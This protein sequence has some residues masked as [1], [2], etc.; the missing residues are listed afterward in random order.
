[1]A[2]LLLDLE[3]AYDKV[4]WPFVLTTIRRMGFR[5][6]D[7]ALGS[8][9]YLN[10]TVFLAD[11]SVGSF[12]RA[13]VRK[14]IVRLS[15]LWSSLLGGWKPLSEVRVVLIG[16]QEVES[17]WRALINALPRE[18]TTILGPQGTD[19]AGT[20][21]IPQQAREEDLVLWKLLEIL[22]SGFKR[23]ERW[24]CTGPENT[25][26]LLE[27][28]TV[29]LWENPA[30][31]R[32]LEV[33]SKNR[34]VRIL[35][36]VRRLPLN[37]LSIDPTAWSWS[38]KDPGKEPLDL[39]NYTVAAGYKQYRHKLKSPAQRAIPLWQAVC[40]EDLSDAE[41][42]FEGLWSIMSSLPN[43]K[44]AHAEVDSPPLLCSYED[45]AARLIPTLGTHAQGQDM[46]AASSP[47]GSGDL[48]SSSGS[49]RNSA[50]EFNIEV[51]DPLTSEDFAWLPLLTTGRLPGPQCAALCAHLHTYLSFYAPPTSLTDDEAA[52]GDIIVYV[53][54]LAR[55][56]RKQRYND[57]NAPLLY[58]RIQVGQASCSALLD[59]GASRNFMSQAFM[60]RAGLGTQVR[61]KAN[62]T[63]INLADGRTQQLIDRYIEAVP[64]YFAP[65]ACEPVMFDILNTDF[66]IVL[67]MP[68]L[69]SADHK[70]NFHRRTLTVR[71]AFGAEVSCTIPLPHPPIRCQVVTAKSFRATCAYEQPGEIGLCF[72]LTVAVAD[73]SPT[74]LSSDPRVVRLLDEF[75]DIFESPTGVVPDRPISHEIILEAGAVPLK[76][77]IYR[78]SEEELTVLCAQLDNLLD[79]GWIRPSNSPYGAPVLF[80]RKKNRNLRLCI[81]YRKLNAQTVKNAGPLPRI[82][83][84]LE[85]LGGATYF[86][87][88]DL[89][90]GYHQILIRSNNRYK[91]AFKTRY[92][93]FEWVVMPFRLTN[94]PTTFQAA[95]TNEFRTVL[96]RFVLVYLD[97][98]LL[99]PNGGLPDAALNKLMKMAST[100]VRFTG[101]KMLRQDSSSNLSRMLNKFQQVF[102]RPDIH[103]SIQ[104]TR[105]LAEYT[106][107]HHLTV[108][109]CTCEVNF[110]LVASWQAQNH[111]LGDTSGGH[112]PHHLHL[113]WPMV[114]KASEFE[115][116]I[117][118]DGVFFGWSLGVSGRVLD[119]GGLGGI[120]GEMLGQYGSNGEV[121]GISGDI[122][123]VSGVGDL[124]DRGRGDWLLEEVESVLA[125][126][127][128]IE[129]LV[130]ACESVKRVRDLGKVENE[131]AVIVGKV[132][133]GTELKEGLERGVL[134][135]GCDLRGVHMDA[136]SGD[137]VAKDRE[138]LANV[139]KVGL[140][141]GAK[142]E[143]V[144]KVQDDTDVEEVTTDVVHGGLECGGGI[145]ESERHYEELVVPGP[146]A[147]CGLVGILLA[148]TDLV[149]ATAEVDLGEIF[150]SLEAIKKFRYPG[151][152][153]LVLDR[154]PVQG[155]FVET[156]GW[157]GRRRS[158]G[159]I[160]VFHPHKVG[161]LEVLNGELRGVERGSV[162]VVIEGGWSGVVR[163]YVMEEAGAER[164][165]RGRVMGVEESIVVKH[166]REEVSKRHV[167][168]VGEG[169]CEI[170]VA[171]S[172]DAGDERRVGN[173]GGG[174]VMAEGA[175][176]LDEAVRGT[177]LAEVTKLFE[178]VIDGFLGAEG[179]SEKVGPLEEGVTRSSGGAAVAD[180]GHPPFGGIVEEAGGGNGKPMDKGHVVE[181]ERV[182]E[183]D[184]EEE[185]VLVGKAGEGHDVGGSEGTG[186]LPFAGNDPGEGVEVEVIG[187][188]VVV[189]VIELDVVVKEVVGGKLWH[190]GVN[191]EDMLMEDWVM[192]G[193]EGV[194][195]GSR[196]EVEA[197]AV[198]VIAAAVAPAA[199]AAAALAAAR[200]EVLVWR[201]GM[202]RWGGQFL[203]TRIERHQSSL[204]LK[205]G[206]LYAFEAA[207]G[208]DCSFVMSVLMATAVL[209]IVA[210]PCH[211]SNSATSAV[212]H[213]QCHASSAASATVPR[214]QQCHV[215]NSAT[216]AVPR[217]Q[218]HVSNSVTSACPATMTGAALGM[219]G[220]LANESL[221]D[222][223]QRFQDQLA[224]IEAEEQR[225]PAAEAARL[226]AEAAA[227][228]EK[229][230]LQAE[231]DADA[232]ARRKEAQD[233]LRRHE[234]ASI[235]RLKFRHF[236]PSNGD[237]ATPEE[238][239]KEFLSKLMTRLLYACNYQ[240][241]ELERQNQEL[242]QQYQDLKTQHQELANL[243]RIV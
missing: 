6:G 55:E 153:V 232:Q 204:M 241:S 3:K 28:V 197:V 90:S 45:Y 61:R 234:A 74:D 239:H 44:Q 177:G 51:W 110:F 86:S 165:G 122:E 203:F 162:E 77:C 236:Q 142:D 104:G 227:T 83:D 240:Q 229:Q 137:N 18:W 193:E 112:Y 115:I 10:G 22:P 185:N 8:K 36:W 32:V 219:P 222:Y 175:N 42:D 209:Q 224:L 31:A 139:L 196:A 136:F 129:G 200:W 117:P 154:D 60:Q 145:G 96:D 128:P 151:E 190:C 103:A 101:L 161:G 57:N 49:S 7:S 202:W 191:P 33:C 109:D 208:R 215:S 149:E 84:L 73:S 71:D 180:F 2:V 169:G 46:C 16:L 223:K 170:F 201:G 4:G 54:K 221:A 89:K 144:I 100:V 68:R 34:S 243:R 186:D 218:C 226:Q 220:Q 214:Q 52:V 166:A 140:K 212:P 69:A 135:E 120:A 13:W 24:K 211:I 97:D 157:R 152:W 171:Y 173:D 148:D 39:H 75:A 43:V 230:R 17:H 228:A 11:G 235:E 5:E 184:K 183:L 130:L 199:A 134:D 92:G 121:G 178:V 174:E 70:V 29:Q 87:K 65:H 41:S 67:G 85:R 118:G 119:G 210:G 107:N 213:Q 188:S 217:Q 187:G 172:L 25:L 132:E 147:E 19:P 88:L 133:E 168:F 53:T 79:K 125:A 126:I 105:F 40:E 80:V 91:S 78:M 106:N 163:G 146:R 124:E 167:G 189:G 66:D 114:C 1:M 238:P 64:V 95:M 179:G 63:T 59:S 20:W 26:Y 164:S 76:G 143:D 23:I 12:G 231:A 206:I 150:G 194:D 237:D 15:D 116:D 9:P 72:L 198:D 182:F 35:T 21:Y 233:L 155:T 207:S 38:A 82:I 127:V 81:N 192:V 225:Q 27:E 98:I 99:Y 160:L 62:P 14:G 58:V 113:P 176:V 159:T 56:F 30:Q 93:H 37:Q 94:A 156:A 242:Q 50:H 111:L 141:G 123:M 216:S 205:R 138:D 195:D 131:R 108:Q 48:S 47:S 102:S 158:G 181:L